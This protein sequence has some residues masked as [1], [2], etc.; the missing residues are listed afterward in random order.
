MKKLILLIILILVV[1]Y[2]FLNGVP[3][4]GQL[5]GGSDEE[6]AYEESAEDGSDEDS[7]E[8]LQ[9][10]GKLHSTSDIGLYDV[11][12]AGTNYA[13]TYNGEEFRAQYYYDNWT[14]YDSYKITNKGDMKI[15]CQALIDLH[16]IHGSDMESY[17][18]ADDMVYEWKQHNLAYKYLPEDNAWRSNA[19]NVDFD[20]QDQGR[21]FEEIYEARTGQDIDLKEKVKEKVEE[22]I[23]DGTF[24]DKVKEYVFH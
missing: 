6:T 3:D 19:E 11:D 9:L 5:L 2:V 14:I 7:G 13:F 24:F 23:E 4:V 20:P 12:G 22:S 16:P 1:G 18:T 15:I 8:G 17:R 10:T 21:S